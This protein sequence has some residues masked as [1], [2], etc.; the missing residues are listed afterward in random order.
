MSL[1]DIQKDVNEWT[2]QFEP[3]YWPPYQILARL[4]EETGE[5]SR[6][7]NHLYGIK[8]KKINEKSNSLGQELTDI[9]F[10]VVCMANSHNIDLQKEW[11]LMRQEK[12][13]I[14]DKNRYVK[15]KEEHS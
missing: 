12:L 8:K 11:D 2:C 3:Q 4:M 9:I 10:T 7:I 5:V 6:E 13:N 15:A 14:R 1:N